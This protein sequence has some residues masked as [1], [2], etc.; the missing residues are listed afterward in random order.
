MIC[1]CALL[2]LF[3]VSGHTA[4]A[5]NTWKMAAKELTQNMQI[6]LS[7]HLENSDEVNAFQ[8]DLTLPAGLKLAGTPILSATRSSGHVLDWTSLN[9]HTYRCIVYSTSNA[10]LNGHTGEL[11][12]IPVL[13]ESSYTDGQVQMT[14]LVLTNQKAENLSV[15]TEIGALSVKKQ[16]IQVSASGLLQTVSS[17]KDAEI[18]VTTIPANLDPGLTIKYNKLSRKT[19]GAYTVKVTREADGSYYEVDTTFR[20]V[21]I[22]KDQPKVT[23]L[24]ASTLNE[25]QRLAQSI[26]SGG[27]ATFTSPDCSG[28]ESSPVPGSFAWLNPEQVVSATAQY[29]A[30]FTPTD[31]S[32]YAQVEVPVQV[33]VNPV[34]HV[35]FLPQ[36]G[37]SLQ[38]E[39]EHADQTY[40]SGQTL[41]VTAVPDP[42]YG[43]VKWVGFTGTKAEE[44]ISVTDNMTISPV[45]E[46]PKYKVTVNDYR[47]QV[48]CDGVSLKNGVNYCAKGSTLLAQF[49]PPDEQT[50]LESLKIGGVERTKYVVAGDVEITISTSWRDTPPL[51]VQ[52]AVSGDGL[53][54]VRLFKED[55]STILSGSAM[56][57]GDKFSVI[58]VPEPGYELDVLNVSGATLSNGIYTLKDKATVTAK[59]KK[60]TYALKVDTKGPGKLTVSP[61]KTSYAYGDKVTVSASEGELYRLVVNGKSIESG[62][63]YTITG[64]TRIYAQFLDRQPLNPEFIKQDAQSYVFNNQYQRFYLYLSNIY[65]CWNFDVAY[66]GLAADE[67]A[68]L[69][70]GDYDVLITRPADQNYEAFSL[71][72]PNALKVKKAKMRV[73]TAPTSVDKSDTDNLGVTSPACA[74]TPAIEKV[75]GKNYLYKFTYSPSETDAANYEPVDYYY[76]NSDTKYPLTI[77]E[78]ASLLKSEQEKQGYVLV[79]NGNMVVED[80]SQIPGETKL[81]LQAIAKPGNKFIGWKQGESG[82]IFHRE[83]T[84]TVLMDSELSYTPVFAGKAEL[85]ASLS[86][87]E[88]PS[89]L[90]PS[91]T[92]TA[93]EGTAPTDYQVRF[94]ADKDGNQPIDPLD[95]KQAGET[96][97]VKVYRDEDDLFKELKSDVLSFTVAQTTIPADIQ[98]VWPEPTDILLGESLSDSKLVGGSAG[99]LEGSFAWKEGQSDPTESGTKSYTVV[100][101]PLDPNYLSTEESI[102]VNVLSKGS[103][104]T[105]TE[106]EPDAPDTPADT[107]ELPD[108]PDTPDQPEA[109]VPVVAER[110]PTT[111]VITWNKVD[112]A[113]SYKL[114]LYAKKGDAEPLKVYEFDSNGQLKSSAISFNLTELEEGKSY[115]I[116]TVAYKG[117]SVLVEKSIE[118]S[119]TPTSLEEVLSNAMITTSYHQI[120]VTTAVPVS[121]RVVAMTGQILFDQ[122]SV[123]GRKEISVPNSGVYMVILY[124]GR[125]AI[126]QKVIVK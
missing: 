59:F 13:V 34:Y 41:K 19:E 58:C 57:Q 62:Q 60:S 118:L 29:V 77:G 88:V 90:L 125:E 1:L 109:S 96:Y 78:N 75:E 122:T 22:S 6:A 14:T 116:T 32:R 126:L 119:A 70:A 72:L 117:E 55:G 124:Q 82:E 3:W 97:Y 20:M 7:L 10:N 31:E 28:S 92:I 15:T 76:S 108:V 80:L 52:A 67:Q 79:T 35:Y 74:G 12:S 54:T 24:S 69:N 61:S 47:V 86:S 23:G 91:I 71:S 65:A 114:F 64:S 26:L 121:V 100:F 36:A 83:D 21:L 104:T 99:Y 101:T 45:F 115:Y 33:E 113:T 27:T 30:L 98:I 112:G 120:Q 107:P 43:F 89:G 81:T 8:F 110:T 44:E 73:K 49:T 93:S 95:V 16:R 68:P 87:E 51:T 39:G 106:K 111:A 50:V 84:L 42:N 5:G 40:V 123:T 105:E 38:I 9:E 25:G 2:L 4:L 63:E 103:S 46:R 11:L 85:T 56:S 66:P 18:S 94:F 48:T 37:G 53:G 102:S 17:E